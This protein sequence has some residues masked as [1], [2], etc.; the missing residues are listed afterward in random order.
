[1]GW[2]SKRLNVVKKVINFP[3]F[4]S[5]AFIP[6]FFQQSEALVWC[7]NVFWHKTSFPCLNSHRLQFS[8]FFTLTYTQQTSARSLCHQPHSFHYVISCDFYFICWFSLRK[9]SRISDFPWPSS[10]NFHHSTVTLFCGFSFEIRDFRH[11]KQSSTDG[12]EWI[13]NAWSFICS[14]KL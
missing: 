5:F 13:S 9:V 11:Q 8:R 2:K 3:L 14:K 12:D 4:P 10:S 7:V 1:M 6:F